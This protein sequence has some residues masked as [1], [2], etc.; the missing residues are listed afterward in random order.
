MVWGRL[1]IVSKFSSYREKIAHEKK[2][3][4]VV[5]VDSLFSV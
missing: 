4:I 2:G 3:S 1:E 5:L